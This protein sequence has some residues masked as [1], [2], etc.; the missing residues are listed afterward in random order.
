MS[1]IL[2]RCL[3]LSLLLLVWCQLTH[4]WAEHEDRQ[5]IH[6]CSSIISQLSGDC[7]L[8]IPLAAMQIG[9]KITLYLNAWQAEFESLPQNSLRH[10]SSYLFFLCRTHS[11]L[12]RSECRQ[13][14]FFPNSQ[15]YEVLH[16]LSRSL[17]I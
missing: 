6:N 17:A 8:P 13:W 15:T 16:S 14:S 9:W 12:G 5:I 11:F 7:F 3:R 2:W 10:E 1:A 4:R